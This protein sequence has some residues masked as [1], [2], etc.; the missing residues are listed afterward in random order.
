MMKVINELNA[1]LE[2]MALVKKISEIDD[3][4]DEHIELI[5]QE[6]ELIKDPEMKKEYDKTVDG[7]LELIAMHDLIY[8]EICKV[9]SDDEESNIN[10]KT[11]LKEYRDLNF[12]L[13]VRYGVV[14]KLA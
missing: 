11:S 1:T 8:N 14:A 7:A 5:R 6:I 2:R 3:L 9:Y 10:F 12:K 13:L 4:L